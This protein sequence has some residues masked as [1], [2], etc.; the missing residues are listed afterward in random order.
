[1]LTKLRARRLK[2][3]L[4]KRSIELPQFAYHVHTRVFCVNKPMCRLLGI[5][6][7]CCAHKLAF[8]ELP[9]H[10]DDKESLEQSLISAIEEHIEWCHTVRILCSDDVS[11]HKYMQMMGQLSA[12]QSVLDGTCVDVTHLIHEHQRSI[13]SLQKQH[14]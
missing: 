5:G 14:M 4:Q 12:D 2:H 11:R 10:I 1:M 8:H 7:D 13:A 3:Q 6:T 9:V